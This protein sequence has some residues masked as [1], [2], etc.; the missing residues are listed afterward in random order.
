MAQHDYSI[1]DDVGADVRSDLNNALNAVAT[2]NSGTSAP[3]TTFADQWWLD[4]TNVLLKLRDTT[5]SAWNS[6]MAFVGGV[7]L[8]LGNGRRLLDTTYNS[9]GTSTAYTITTPEA[10]G[11][12]QTG[13]KHWVRW[14]TDATGVFTINR[15]GQ[16]AKNVKVYNSGGT[17]TSATI[18]DA[19]QGAES[20]LEYDGTQFVIKAERIH[21]GTAAYQIP[22]LNSAGMLAEARVAL[23]YRSGRQTIT[24]GANLALTHGLGGMPDIIQ[25]RLE[26]R[27]DDSPYVVD[28]FIDVDLNQSTTTGRVNRSRPTS[29]QV[30]I[31]FAD[32][33]ECFVANDGAGADITLTNSRWRLH[34]NAWRFA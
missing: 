31:R 29:T 20:L 25:Y 21:R 4:R 13:E 19:R 12:Y 8:P 32:N 9:G 17:L 23:A 34:V 7:V 16:G 26:C 11:A 14:H 22:Q 3:S 15:D 18:A 33:A 30:Q 1:A 24:S 10:G 6:V 2:N 28:D 27:T 5:N